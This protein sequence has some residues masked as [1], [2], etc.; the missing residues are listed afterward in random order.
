M[1]ASDYKLAALES[2][3]TAIREGRT[4]R[5]GLY[6]VLGF[7]EPLTL[8]PDGDTLIVRFHFGKPL[9]EW[10]HRFPATAPATEIL[11]WVE[12][13]KQPASD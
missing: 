1:S 6:P 3:L 5:G 10:E 8:E 7:G 9:R 4:R 2:L 12:S 13:V 11:E